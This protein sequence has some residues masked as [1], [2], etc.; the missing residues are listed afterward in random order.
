M[1]KTHSE[2]SARGLNQPDAVTDV[3][4]VA[5]VG[6][7]SVGSGESAV[8]DRFERV[9]P[10]FGAGHSVQFY[11]DDAFL[12][13]TVVDFLAPSFPKGPPAIVIA[14]KQHRETF[15]QRLASAG[16]DVDDARRCGQLTMLDAREMLAT[17]MI[18]GVP[19]SDRFRARIGAVMERSIQQCIKRRIT[20]RNDGSQRTVIRAYGEM[21]DLLWKD[22]NT[23]GAIRLEELWNDLSRRY[24]FS[25]LCAYSMDNFDRSTD[26]P[27]FQEICRQH[28]HVVPAEGYTTAGDEARLVEIAHLQQHARALQAEI[29]HREDLEQRLREE[30][31]AHQQSEARLEAL[32]TASADVVYRMSPDWNEMRQLQGRDVVAG[33]GHAGATWLEK[34]IDPDKRP[35][36]AEVIEQA[37]RTKRIFE[38]EHR[39]VRADGTPGWMYFRAVPMLSAQGD[40]VE[41][42]GMASD[43][44]RR[45]L[46]EEALH[47]TTV[48]A[49]TANRAKSD[50]LA[51]MSH[52]LRTPLN[53]IAGYAQLMAMGVHGPVTEAQLV[54]LGRMQQS[55]QHLLSLVNDVLNFAKIEAG[56][57]EYHIRDTSLEE[58]VA[59][60]ASMMEQQFISRRLIFKADVD[61]SIVV[62]ADGDKVQQILLNLLSNAAKFT[63]PGGEIAIDTADAPARDDGSPRLVLVRVRDTGIG[64]AYDKHDAIFDPFVQLG[65]GL[66]SQVEGAGLGLAISRDLARGMGGDLSAES[67]PGVGSTFTITLPAA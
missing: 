62:R 64:I 27:R 17:I 51:A 59:S 10:S 19:D 3:L 2:R 54:A 20:Q 1:R 11:E 38:L 26:T 47:E 33:A 29:T 15:A 41:W 25:L 21:V 14:T 12:V 65:R 22:G 13:G 32:V 48:Q 34:Y 6:S 46:T 9:T 61:S 37:V 50:F 45:K 63:E 7:T 35:R 18:G 4:A 52:E 30:L 56:R 49:E 57:V 44:T 42:I 66:K 67:T 36:V 39:V 31:S 40:I 8:I 43:V 58:A 16:V 5:M 23:D 53:A 28:T 60:V 24:D 55:E